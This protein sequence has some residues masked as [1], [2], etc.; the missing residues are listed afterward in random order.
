[1]AT[2]YPILISIPHGGTET[3]P[4]LADRVVLSAADLF[5]D[6]DPLTREIYAC[7]DLVTHWLGAEVARTF[8][9]LN[10]RRDDLDNPDGVI[11]KTTCFG[12]PIYSREPEPALIE[13]L[14]TR[15]YDSYH[16][17]LAAHARDAR[18]AIVVDCHSMLAVGP[19]ISPDTGRPRPMMCLGDRNGTSCP[20]ELTS[21]LA[22]SLR[23]AFGLAE[24]EVVC[25]QPFSGGHITRFYAGNPKPSLQ[26]ELNRAL[27]LAEPWFDPETRQVSPARIDE[28][29]GM[30]RSGL[31][32]WAAGTI[33]RSVLSL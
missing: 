21:A 23:H 19:R 3:P 4:E 9:D 10:R 16:R 15:Y 5:D 22:A 20:P 14:L 27:Y 2:P 8:V 6:I 17:A 32:A 1:M 31:E 18:V 7:A 12:V 30:F 24:E 26:I 11:K 25:N 28:L 33:F 29:A 13:T